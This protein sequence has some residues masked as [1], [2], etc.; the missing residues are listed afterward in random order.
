MSA[1]LAGTRVDALAQL[2]GA[3]EPLLSVLKLARPAGRG[4]LPLVVERAV[5]ALRDVDTSR[6]TVR[7]RL[8]ALLLYARPPE[9]GVVLVSARARGGVGRAEVVDAGT[10]EAW[11]LEFDRASVLLGAKKRKEK[12]RVGRRVRGPYVPVSSTFLVVP[13]EA[14]G[15][16]VLVV[17]GARTWYAYEAAGYALAANVLAALYA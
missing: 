15:E 9:E 6:W 13:F 4:E 14:G 16:A 11:A 8:L 7:E 5:L 12:R 2:S 10:G 17:E 3:W 1:R